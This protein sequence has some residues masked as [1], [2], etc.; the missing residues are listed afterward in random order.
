M[1]LLKKGKV[2]DVYELDEDSLKFVFSDRIS[3]F[4]KIIPSEIPRKGETLCKTSAFWFEKLEKKNIKTHFINLDGQNAMNVKKFR[5]LE[6][7][8]SKD[9]NYFIPLEIICRW[10]VAGSL[11]DRIKR[12]EVKSEE[13]GFAPDH[14]VK[15]GDK[16]PAPFIEFT[17]K[18]EKVDRE[19]TEEEAAELAG[20]KKEDIKRIKELVIKIDQIIKKQVEKNN[21]IHV[22][23][24]KE[25]AFDESRELVV[26]DTFGTADEDRW[27]D[28]N[29]YDKGNIVEISKEFVRQ[30]Y[31]KTGYKKI[32][33][34]A[35]KSG[36]DIPIPPL[37]NNLIK[38]TSKL[39]INLF[40][41]ITNKKIDDTVFVDTHDS[42]N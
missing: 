32:L 37:P 19:L 23:G 20:L 21:L 8:T 29:E 28:K 6:R 24:K 11:F 35:R 38:E 10:F 34:A 27:W 18:L 40:E 17:T 14:I 31:R 3:V 42:S 4:D 7:P 1:K 5:I 13:L 39:Y 15:Y 41:R 36:K 26:V 22:D 16:L 30:H 9:N 25:F 12:G 2:K 33:D